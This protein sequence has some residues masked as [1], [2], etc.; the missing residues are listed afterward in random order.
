MQAKKGAKI[1]AIS[2][3]ISQF[4]VA[5]LLALIWRFPIPFSGYESGVL[6]AIRSLPGV[7]FLDILFGGFVVVPGLGAALAALICRF[8]KKK[9]TEL[10]RICIGLGFFTAL[11]AGIFMAV[12][13]K[14]I[15]PW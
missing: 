13:D 3:L 15:G 2:A 12:L 6:A 4:P 10:K 7:I 11:I 1:G 8:S 5:F 14:I 9:E